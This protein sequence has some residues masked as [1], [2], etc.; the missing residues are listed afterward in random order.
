[1]ILLTSLA[2]ISVLWVASLIDVMLILLQ[3]LQ[4]TVVFED[5]SLWD[6]HL[7]NWKELLTF[8]ESVLPLSSGSNKD[9]CLYFMG[10]V[11]WDQVRYLNEVCSCHVLI[12]FYTELFLIKKIISL[13]FV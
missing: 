10:Y 6:L 3:I 5:V 7:I 9:C 13:D 1:M 12:F 11:P 8:Q 2:L 4:Y